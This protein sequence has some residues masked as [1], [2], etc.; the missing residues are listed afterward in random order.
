[1]SYLSA[2]GYRPVDVSNQK[3]YVLSIAVIT[4]IQPSDDSWIVVAFLRSLHRHFFRGSLLHGF[5]GFRFRFRSLPIANGSLGSD[6][7]FGLEMTQFLHQSK[8]REVLPVRIAQDFAF[9]FR[10]GA[11]VPFA[12]Y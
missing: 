2:A 7:S 1:M 8:A 12:I 4:A 9:D 6:P 10:E 3:K 5:L 11:G